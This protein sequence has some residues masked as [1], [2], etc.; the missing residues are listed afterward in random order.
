MAGR[1][2]GHHLGLPQAL[3]GLPLSPLVVGYGELAAAQHGA[4]LRHIGE[5]LAPAGDLRV[6]DGLYVPA[7]G[8][9]ARR[10]VDAA[11]LDDLS[12][13][14]TPTA[15]VAELLAGLYRRDP[16]GPR[17]VV[18][19]QLI[20]LLQESCSVEDLGV[21]P[22]ERAGLVAAA[23][24]RPTLDRRQRDAAESVADA[25]E[26]RRLHRV[27]G[28]V[29]RLPQGD[30]GLER[31][32]TSLTARLANV[33]AAL[34]AARCAEKDGAPDSAS[35]RYL[36]ALDLAADDRRALRGLV[37]VHRPGSRSPLRTELALDHI[38]LD[39]DRA[40][41]D[42]RLL[43]LY[44]TERGEPRVRE[45]P[46]ARDPAVPLGTAVRYAAFPLADGRVA[47]PPLVSRRVLFA[48]EVA[49]LSLTDGRERIAGTWRRPPGATE[50]TV[51]LAAGARPAVRADGFTATGLP[52][53]RHALRVVCHY[54]APDGRL[55]PSPG[56]RATR[57][58][59]RWPEPVRTL[60]ATPDGDTVRFDWT[61]GAGAEVRLVAWP[62][63]PPAP[64]AEL[65]TSELPPAVTSPAA[66]HTRVAAVSVLGERALAG[67]V[68]DVEVLQ[69]VTGLTA[70]RLPDG[71]VSILLDWPEATNQLVV[72]W[73]GPDGEGERTVTAH[74]YRHGG[75]RLP[76]GP[77]EVRLRATA[78]PQAPE[79]VVVTAAGAEYVLPPDAS[80]GYQLVRD[81]RRFLG[82]G[83]TLL[84]VTLSSLGGAG[85][86]EVPEFVCVARS[87]TLRPRSAADGTTV[88][89]IPGT[90]LTRHGTVEQELPAAPL[91]TPYTLRGFLL[92]EHAAAVRLEEPSPATLVVRRP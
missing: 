1:E 47:G 14:A 71:T 68:V 4:G 74:A 32:R 81:R 83:R 46:A 25:W 23:R 13:S 84:R 26:R 38:E 15:R 16:Q 19:Y 65:R 36:R 86:P 54:R 67:P 49:G 77:R 69:P 39:W 33:E 45:V 27:R 7:G 21:H 40:D 60:T 2:F 75:L 20:C 79:G 78:V 28:L 24:L 87:G 62:G 5:A 63:Q 8:P 88:L 72:R 91:P 43:C 59:H 42:W 17:R 3:S 12:G 44:R 76:L 53:G 56:V 30:P 92:G 51:E 18:L 57:T 80:I 29:E 48:P 55:V 90:E 9:R 61:G 85:G 50:V 66:G 89:R 31:L 52:V 73:D 34:A 82:K 37:R 11:L 6:L 22:D 70:R 35:E 41:C 10:R 64:G 58:V